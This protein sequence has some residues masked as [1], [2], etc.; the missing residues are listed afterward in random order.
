ME[1]QRLAAL[2]QMVAQLD[3][4][5]TVK[6]AAQ[7]ATPYTEQTAEEQ[8]EQ[9]AVQLAVKSSDPSK[10]FVRADAMRLIH[11]MKSSNG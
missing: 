2:A 7:R 10:S 8:N 11:E 4:Q 5:R 9:R 6:W 3:A 1:Y